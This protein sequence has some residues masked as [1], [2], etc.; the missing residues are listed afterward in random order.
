MPNRSPND[1]RQAYHGQNGQPGGAH[2]GENRAHGGYASGRPRTT[3]SGG[4]RPQGGA[5][6]TGRGPAAR[7]SA[8]KGPHGKKGM[9]KT[10]LLYLLLGGVAVVLIV[11]ILLVA[12]SGGGPNPP[13]LSGSERLESSGLAAESGYDKDKN[14]LPAGQFAGTILAETEDA[15]EEYVEETL[16]IGD[17]NTER[18]LSYRDVTG[19]TMLNGIGI[20]NMGITMVESLKCVK[21]RGMGAVT[22]PEA[23]AVMQP[24]RIVITFG[25][26]DA[27]ME[28]KNF[29]A[30]Y[31]SAIEAIRA[32][33]P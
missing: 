24:R 27:L 10:T 1:P 16:F 26:N 7:R 21:F 13:A 12:F 33:Y 17:S 14:S 5:G 30:S 29:V 18:M 20:T 9:D 31:R 8:G 6:A 28:T 32:A 19:V 15:G 4:A 25:T 11:A 3:Y 23:V 22:I 2:G